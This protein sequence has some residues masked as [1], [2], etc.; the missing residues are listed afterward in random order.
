MY[1][2][3]VENWWGTPSAAGTDAVKPPRRPACARSSF[4]VAGAYTDSRHA[5]ASLATATTSVT[6]A[7]G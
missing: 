5:T 3:S 1:S 2:K 4:P 6:S 7:T